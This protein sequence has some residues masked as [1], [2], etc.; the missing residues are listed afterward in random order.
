MLKLSGNHLSQGHQQLLWETKHSKRVDHFRLLILIFVVK[1]RLNVV[2]V[3]YLFFNYALQIFGWESF[4]IFLATWG[5]NSPPQFF[6]PAPH[7]LYQTLY[8]RYS[9]PP[10]K[11]LH[12]SYPSSHT[13]TF[14]PIMP[15]I[16]HLTSAAILLALWWV[17]K[18]PLSAFILLAMGCWGL[19]PQPFRSLFSV[20]CLWPLSHGDP[21]SLQIW[22][23]NSSIHKSRP[24]IK[25]CFVT[26][27]H[28]TEKR[29]KTSTLYCKKGDFFKAIFTIWP[30][31]TRF[32]P[33]LKFLHPFPSFFPENK[34]LRMCVQSQ[35]AQASNFSTPD[36]KK[37]NRHT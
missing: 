15:I 29:V 18:S 12:P 36:C 21:Q 33:F 25:Q 10:L 35:A 20:R 4:V 37:T 32:H 26:I 31:L 1:D 30:I 13:M 19:N 22:L 34:N 14:T 16:L 23:S 5:Q 27:F 8:Q 7:P 24:K 9:Y 2:I 6:Y 3:F 28:Y 17:Y 11:T